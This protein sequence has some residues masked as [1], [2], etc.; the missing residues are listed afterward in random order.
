MAETEG[1][2]AT[3]ESIIEEGASLN[4]CHT[5]EGCLRGESLLFTKK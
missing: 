2:L 5:R 1:S 4:G 3:E